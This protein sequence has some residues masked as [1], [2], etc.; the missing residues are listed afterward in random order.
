M[1]NSKQKANSTLT[2]IT[3]K[4]DNETFIAPA[5]DNNGRA[6][7]IIAGFSQFS[8]EHKMNRQRIYQ[9]LVESNMGKDV[10][11]QPNPLAMIARDNADLF[12]LKFVKE[13]ENEY[14]S[15]AVHVYYHVQRED[16]EVI[17]LDLGYVPAWL[18]K[19]FYEDGFD[20]LNAD[21][22]NIFYVFEDKEFINFKVGMNFNFRGKK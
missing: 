19:I 20:M 15:N 4:Y 18:N 9:R 14:D 11:L 13:P 16:G 17:P 7:F 21:I 22:M 3:P 8:R 1:A 5:G 2:S 10:K 6:T 12:S